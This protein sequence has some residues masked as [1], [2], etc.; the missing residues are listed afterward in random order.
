VRRAT[1]ARV[2]AVLGDAGPVIGDL[3]QKRNM[4]AKKTQIL[5]F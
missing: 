4:N 3:L 1:A 2:T 5:Y